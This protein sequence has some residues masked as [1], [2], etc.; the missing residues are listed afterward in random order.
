MPMDTYIVS[1]NSSE[2]FIYWKIHETAPVSF[3]TENFI[4][5]KFGLELTKKQITCILGMFLM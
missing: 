5:R 1:Y 4:G 2:D 3:T